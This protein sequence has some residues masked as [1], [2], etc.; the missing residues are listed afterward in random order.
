MI[1]R[2]LFRSSC[3]GS[4]PSAPTAWPPR[5]S[6]RCTGSAA[7]PPAGPRDPALRVEALGLRFPSPLGVA[8]GFDKDA[9]LVRGA[10]RARLRLR[11]GRHG[12]RRS[13]QPGNPRP[14]ITPPADRALLNRHGLPQPRR[15]GGRARGSPGAARARSS[16][17]TSA[18]ARSRRR[19]GASTTTARAVRGARPARRLPRAQ[20]QLAE[21]AGP[22]RPAGRRGAAARSSPR[23]RRSS[24]AL[25]PRAPL[26][27]KIAPD[28]ADED[29]DAVADLALELR[30]RR[31]HRDQHDDRPR[32]A[33][34]RAATRRPEPAGSRARRSQ[35]RALE[36]LRRLRARV[37]DEL[38]LVA[39][40][41]DRERRRR[42]G[43][44]PGR[45]D[46]RAGLHRASS[47]AARLGPPRQPRARREP[48]SRDRLRRPRLLRRSWARRPAGLPRSPGAPELPQS[49]EF[50]PAAFPLGGGPLYP[51]E[52][53]G[54]G[55]RASGTL[56][57][58][59]HPRQASLSLEGRIFKAAVERPACI[60][61]W[62]RQQRAG[63]L[64]S[65]HGPERASPSRGLGPRDEVLSA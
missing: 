63:R 65:E 32:P 56:V 37:G 25:G 45:R 36:V 10:R 33:C 64:M 18:S 51:A 30:A 27:V 62:V 29:I 7:A 3:S 34:R 13:A 48:S 2:L 39:V 20:R 52:L 53:S 41:G 31:D 5:C 6:G 40:G 58:L 49:M 60:T 23:C 38:V 28:L 14:R 8:A 55:P 61:I 42:L 57:R 21:H 26:L 1:Y 50:E 47:T 59:R 46:A 16:A 19:R 4:R 54:A 22:A 15:G 12:H 24:R 11:R 44:H 43:A 17:S 9:T 35:A